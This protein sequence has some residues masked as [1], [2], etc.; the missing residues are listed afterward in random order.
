[1]SAPRLCVSCGA[2]VFNLNPKA[3]TCGD[4]I[5]YRAYKEE[6]PRAEVLEEELRKHSEIRVDQQEALEESKLVCQ[7][8]VRLMDK[9]WA[10]RK[11]LVSI[12]SE[13]VY[14]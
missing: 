7:Q 10:G 1:M 4:E 8:G 5:C 13:H 14:D 3:R 12:P 6:R 2:R 11:K 9:I